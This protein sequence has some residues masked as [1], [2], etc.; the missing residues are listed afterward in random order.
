MVSNYYSTDMWPRPTC[1]RA[2]PCLPAS[3]YQIQPTIIGAHFRKIWR[4]RSW[5][6]HGCRGVGSGRAVPIPIWLRGLGEHHKLFQYGLGQS[7][8][9]SRFVVLWCKETR[10]V[11][12]KCRK[13]RRLLL[14][15]NYWGLV[16]GWT[17][18]LKYWGWLELEAHA[19]CTKSAPVPT[20][21]CPPW[22]GPV[23]CPDKCLNGL[24]DRQYILYS[25]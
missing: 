4:E 6:R 18:G 12:Q 23:G 17:P 11:T 19:P 1:Y 10:S 13:S 2:P 20:H 21:L 8:S 15:A 7:P 14:R 16:A 5:R 3:L 25:Y 22:V 24:A 9:H